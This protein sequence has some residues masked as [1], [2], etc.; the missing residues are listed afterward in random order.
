M[1]PLFRLPLRDGCHSRVG[2]GE[3]L[4]GATVLKNVGEPGLGKRVSAFTCERGFPLIQG[5]SIENIKAR[6]GRSLQDEAKQTSHEAEEQSVGGQRS[7]GDA[8]GSPQESSARLG[9]VYPLR[10]LCASTSLPIV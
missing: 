6:H 3:Q 2:E 1:L 8:W 4:A 7:L 9:S 5:F 10:L